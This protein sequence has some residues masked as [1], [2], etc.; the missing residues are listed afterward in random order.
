MQLRHVVVRFRRGFSTPV[1]L[2]LCPLLFS[3]GCAS[4]YQKAQ[5]EEV[6]KDLRGDN[7][8]MGQAAHSGPM[9]AGLP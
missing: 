9:T 1:Y 2:V 8:Q 4:D 6:R 7:M 3:I 5:W